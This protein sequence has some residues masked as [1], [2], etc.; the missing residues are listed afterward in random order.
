MRD[1]VTTA[2]WRAETHAF[3][4]D[5]REQRTRVLAERLVETI[6][7]DH[8]AYRRAGVVSHADLAH[9]CHTNVAAILDLIVDAVTGEGPRPEEADD[10]A[11]WP[12]R[13]TGSL[14][15]EQGQPLDDVLRSFRVGGRLI[16]DDLLETGAERLDGRAL[17]EVGSLLWEAV[18][19]TSARVASAYH[20]RDRSRVRSDVERRA[21]LWEGV[22]RGRA[23]DPGFA[24]EASEALDLPP[25]GELVVTVA[26]PIEPQAAERGVAPHAAAFL[27]R[28]DVTVGLVALREDVPDA[29]HRALAA[30]AGG[31]EQ[32]TVAVS[33]VVVG[34]GGADEGYRQAR[35]AL[36][37]APRS[38]GLV[39]YEDVLPEALLLSSPDVAD[40]LRTRWITPLHDLGEEGRMLLATLE[41]WVAAGGSAS[42]AAPLVPCHRNTVLNRL[43][44]VTQVTG[45][46]LD[47][48]TPPV[49][50]DLALR[51]RRLRR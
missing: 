17:R 44:R 42:R 30:L 5:H 40:R 3:L 19:A 47:D 29:A 13:T 16:W 18:D 37:S 10:T 26:E 15:A 45:L 9:S 36:R 34:L 21:T 2:D 8:L 25:G 22:L 7:D 50:L 6:E 46:P 11:F 48:D 38:G 14:R 1:T 12:A 43:R 41:A 31:P 23:R 20:H 32:R 39:R 27:R 51:A 49:D 4:L 24:A 28:G 33:A 35:L